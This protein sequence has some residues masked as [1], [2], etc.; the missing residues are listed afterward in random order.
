MSTVHK[1]INRK[2]G[3]SHSQ[4]RPTWSILHEKVIGLISNLGKL[5]N[6]GE[7]KI[8]S[9]AGTS[10][11]NSGLQS[12]RRQVVG[13]VNTWPHCACSRK[14]DGEQAAPVPMPP[15]P[16]VPLGRVTNWEQ[17][18]CLWAGEASAERTRCCGGD[19]TAAKTGSPHVYALRSQT[20]GG[21]RE[22][23]GNDLSIIFLL[24]RLQ[25]HAYQD[26]VCLHGYTC[27]HM[28]AF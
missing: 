12:V 7:I 3:R 26:Y 2:K 23:C 1:I 14:G 5:N 19:S 20:R 8:K 11:N 10:E 28:S 24:M 15:G 18:Q 17:L 4:K 13:Q 25:T 16:A 9:V 6:D 21:R 27:K 22:R